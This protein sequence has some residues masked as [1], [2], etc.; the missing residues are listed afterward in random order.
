MSRLKKLAVQCASRSVHGGVAGKPAASCC[1][2]GGIWLQVFPTLH[3]LL[4]YLHIAQPVFPQSRRFFTLHTQIWN[5]FGIIIFI[6]DIKKEPVSQEEDSECKIIEVVDLTKQV[7]KDAGQTIV[8]L[9]AHVSL[10]F[11]I[12]WLQ[13]YVCL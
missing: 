7:Q 11:T 12:R 8:E 3:Y 13:L 1:A 9:K 6:M 5:Y 10:K 4:T 2:H